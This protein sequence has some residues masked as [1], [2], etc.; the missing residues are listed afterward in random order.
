[1]TFLSERNS[2]SQVVHTAWGLSCVGELLM[3]DRNYLARHATMLLRLARL[4]ADR[5][6]AANLVDK[7]AD[8][9]ARIDESNYPDVTPLAPDVEPPRAN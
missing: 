4:T 2:C 3:I 9:K 1:Y 7:A 6:V 8:L 5:D